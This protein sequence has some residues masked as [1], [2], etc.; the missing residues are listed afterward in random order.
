MLN[1]V[2]KKSPPYHVAQDDVSATLQRLEL[3]K[4]TDQKS[5]RG[6]GGVIAVLYKTHLVRLS[7][8]SL[9]REMD[10]HLSRTHSLGYS[11]GTPEQHR[12]PNRLYHRM[13]TGQHI[14]S[15]PG[16]TGNVF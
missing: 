2:S 4:I 16:P 7:K 3:E 1:I 5:F 9:G 15:P 12:Q 13:R 10:L 8:P 14:V 6:R 11:A